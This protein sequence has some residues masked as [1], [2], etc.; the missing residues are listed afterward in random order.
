[1][2]ILLTVLSVGLALVLVAGTVLGS[3][4]E[5]RKDRGHEYSKSYESKIYGTINKVPEGGFGI[6]VVNGKD[7]LVTKD[8]FIDEEHGR[9]AAGAFAEVKGGYDGKTFK[10]FKIEIKRTKK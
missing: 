5:R 6:W 3:D 10:A 9:A 8:T 1:M 2:K 7:V 4:Y